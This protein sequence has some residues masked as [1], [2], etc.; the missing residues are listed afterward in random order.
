MLTRVRIEAAAQTTEDVT[1]DLWE[2]AWVIAHSL[3]PPGTPADSPF[4]HEE[5]ISRLDDTERTD[6]HVYKGRLVIGLPV[7]WDHA[8]GWF[9][10]VAARHGKTV[11]SHGT[12]SPADR[13]RLL[14]E[15]L[16]ETPPGSQVPPGA[17]VDYGRPEYAMVAAD[18]RGGPGIDVEAVAN[19]VIDERLREL[20]PQPITDTPGEWTDPVSDPT[21]PP[22]G[23][24]IR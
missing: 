16:N 14:D 2:L 15:W 17:R 20:E 13:E 1:H 11:P 22:H 10:I 8:K 3:V 18:M 4:I 7:D 24:T 9:E 6:A 19:R 5:V 12:I 23:R 21:D